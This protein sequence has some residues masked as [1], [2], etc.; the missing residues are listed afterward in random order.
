LREWVEREGVEW[1]VRQGG[2]MTQVLYAHMNNKKIK[3]KKNPKNRKNRSLKTTS[4]E[5]VGLPNASLR[6][7]YS[8][9]PMYS[10]RHMCGLL[11]SQEYVE[12]S[13]LYAHLI[14]QFLLLSI[15]ISLI[16]V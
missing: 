7:V 15:W 8:T 4:G 2:E 12:F 13:N 9:T 5:S 14:T 6:H 3:I 16:F 11:D 1:V 10:H